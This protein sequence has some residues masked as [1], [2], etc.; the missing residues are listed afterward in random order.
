[1]LNQDI[2]EHFSS[3]N[4]YVSKLRETLSTVVGAVER[5]QARAS[6]QQKLIPVDTP[7]DIGSHVSG[8][9][10]TRRHCS[11]SGTSLFVRRGESVI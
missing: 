3:V 10:I 9:E 2:Q 5:H 11:D 7:C 1:M 8:L 4:D 6:E